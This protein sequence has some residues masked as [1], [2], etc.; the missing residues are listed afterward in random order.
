MALTNALYA[1]IPSFQEAA[2]DTFKRVV[3]QPTLDR[4]LPED[5]LL[6]LAAS[7]LDP[8]AEDMQALERIGA[9]DPRLGAWPD[10]LESQGDPME[11]EARKSQ[12]RQKSAFAILP[13]AAFARPFGGFDRKK[14]KKA[15]AANVNSLTRLEHVEFDDPEE[16]VK[17]RAKERRGT[18]DTISRDD[19]EAVDLGWVGDIFDDL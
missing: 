17:E 8:E 13:E 9:A 6:R 15:K 18:A 10:M 5:P 14:K 2:P 16:R 4:D 1:P 12:A 11:G 19:P 7:G 3:G